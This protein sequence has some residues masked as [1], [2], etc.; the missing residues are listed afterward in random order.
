MERQTTLRLSADSLSV[1]C[2]REAH[3]LLYPTSLLLSTRM[4]SNYADYHYDRELGGLRETRT[5]AHFLT[6]LLILSNGHYWTRTSDL[7][8]VNETL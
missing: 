5:H 4:L 6:P 8:D 3:Y 2:A 7:L 1:I